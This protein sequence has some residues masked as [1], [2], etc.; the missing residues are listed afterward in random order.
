MSDSDKQF[1]LARYG[2][3]KHVDQ[4]LDS[5]E[6]LT[7]R[8]VAHR[9]DLTPEHLEKLLTHPSG[10]VRDQAIAHH[11]EK[12]SDT[13]MSRAIDDPHTKMA[14]INFTKNPEHL[15]KAIYDGVRNWHPAEFNMK[16]RSH[17][18]NSLTR[19]KQMGE[20]QPRHTKMVTDKIQDTN[21]RQWMGSL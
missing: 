14:A 17:I 21:L 10:E 18:Q 15:E 6:W 20:L 11:H 2:S 9:D 1:F 13:Q 19:L 16:Q 12:M 3:H 5:G 7:G 8:R 4:I